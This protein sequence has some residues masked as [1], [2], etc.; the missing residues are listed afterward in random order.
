MS[1]LKLYILG[2]PGEFRG[3]HWKREVEESAA[4]LGWNVVH[5][6]AQS[7]NPEEVLRECKDADIF[8]WLRTHRNDPH[9]DAF[10]AWTTP[11]GC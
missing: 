8:L 3:N 7:A 5:R 4:S 1:D 6:A 2:F 11:R 10:H 9:G